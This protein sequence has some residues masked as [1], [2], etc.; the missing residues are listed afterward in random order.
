MLLQAYEILQSGDGSTVKGT[1]STTIGIP[2]NLLAAG[3][4]YSLASKLKGAEH[5]LTKVTEADAYAE[6]AFGFEA[7]R[8]LAN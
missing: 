5:G 7:W 4:F 8:K 2:V 6:G 3:I 1:K